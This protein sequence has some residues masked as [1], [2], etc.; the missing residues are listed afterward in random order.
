[1]KFPK[2]KKVKRSTLSNRADKLFS[3]KIRS[4]GYCVLK[5]MDKVKCGGVLQCAHIIGRANRRLRWD[6][7]NALCLCSGHHSYYT[8]H[9]W[10]WSLLIERE[11]PNKYK[12]LNKH[13]NEI[14]DKD[15]SKVLEALGK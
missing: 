13:R 6:L 2:P 8:N 15:Y 3:L 4:L 14:W 1:M 10:E 11:F 7:N 9:A 5:D 12:Y